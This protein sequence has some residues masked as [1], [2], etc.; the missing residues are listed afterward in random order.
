MVIISPL[1]VAMT[2]FPLLQVILKNT[3][4]FSIHLNL[5]LIIN[6][7]T[8]ET[9]N[10]IYCLLDIYT[11]ESKHMKH[12][13]I[14]ISFFCMFFASCQED[15]SYLEGSAGNKPN[16][17]VSY[18]PSVL[19]TEWIEKNKTRSQSGKEQYPDWYGG[20]FQENGLLIFQ[21]TDTGKEYLLPRGTEYHVCKYSYNQ[22][23]SIT[24][25]IG[26][27]IMTAEQSCFSN[28]VGIGVSSKL[29][30]IQVIMYDTS[31]TEIVKFKNNVYSDDEYI[32][33]TNVS[34]LSNPNKS[35]IISSAALPLYPDNY[36]ECGTELINPFT[37]HAASFGYRVHDE[38]GNK[39]FMTAGHFVYEGKCVTSAKG[40][41]LGLCKQ[42]YR[43]NVMDASYCELNNNNF[44]LSNH[45]RM[46]AVDTLSAKSVVPADNDYITVIGYRN[47]YQ[48][49][50][51]SNSF[52]FSFDDDE[53]K[54][55]MYQDQIIMNFASDLGNSGGV[56]IHR[57]KNTNELL[58]VGILGGNCISTVSPV[59]GQTVAFCCKQNV[60]ESYMGV[61]RY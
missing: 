32:V 50:V 12:L 30:R 24:N 49:Q 47:A 7:S 37:R 38:N 54:R 26:E 1:T 35:G 14:L 33:F 53:G 43:R 31:P 2:A 56:V 45:I 48:A 3:C 58:T 27:K 52:K 13:Y 57:D 4:A 23:D 9:I 6:I 42:C 51:I 28:I 60:I 8:L 59:L 29:N 5:L 40:D 10:K 41:T 21:C 36:I 16:P 19:Y 44:E 11:K 46:Y 39:G 18:D 55:C 20:C 34:D 15:L 61:K 22:L 25:I 17:Y